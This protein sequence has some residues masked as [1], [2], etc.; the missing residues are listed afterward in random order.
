MTRDVESTAAGE[1][2]AQAAAEMAAAKTAAETAVATKTESPALTLPRNVRV[3]AWCSLLNDTSSEMVY[4][5]LPV[6]L[7]ST[8]RGTTADLGVIEGVAESTA[9]LLK[10]WSGQRSD[11]AER[12]RGFILF[13]YIVAVVA[14]GLC[15]LASAP[16]HLFSLRTLDRVGKGVRA[17]PRDALIAD[18]TDATNRGRAFGYHRAMDHL[19]AILG[20]LLA[21]LWL[22]W[23][24]HQLST[25]FWLTIIPG[26]AV[27]VILLLGLR[28]T[29]R[30]TAGA[31]ASDGAEEAAEEAAE[32]GFQQAVA[33]TE[34]AARTA[35]LLA[36]EAAAA[37][38]L[39][40]SPVLDRRFQTYLAA[41]AIFSLG[42]SSD[43][44]LL[45][46]A[47]ELGV[48]EAWLPILWAAL[49]GVK[50]YGN[51][52]AGRLVDRW[53]ARPLII[54][55]WFIYAVIYLL[56]AAAQ[57][58]WQVC[59]LFLGY[60]LFYALTEPAERALVVQLVGAEKKGR[61]FGYFHLTVGLMSLPASVLCGQLYHRAGPWAAFGCGAAL[62]F[63]ASL[64]LLY[65]SRDQL[66][67]P[68]AKV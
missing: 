45:N 43:T 62:A 31:G 42:N 47:N 67:C 61:A 63:V 3:L 8:L 51:M 5:L 60:G 37:S 34:E 11:R 44:F 2:A 40:R 22:S 6:F 41:L 46:R 55:G 26:V 28:E 4:P 35:N 25:L 21:F 9:S 14:R 48:T 17:A 19:G 15:A 65:G 52:L 32:E 18:S 38:V 36:S 10:L 24:P 59:A 50:S 56:F 13:G 12:R 57:S 66:Q 23:F 7:R 1:T 27:V 68:A 64:M 39:E 53:S 29:V 16:W 49:H 20:P 33:A 58:T 30:G 54:A